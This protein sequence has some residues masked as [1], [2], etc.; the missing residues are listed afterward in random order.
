[1][2]DLEQ[3]LGYLPSGYTVGENVSFS[4]IIIKTLKNKAQ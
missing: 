3:E 1:V 2:R 4:T